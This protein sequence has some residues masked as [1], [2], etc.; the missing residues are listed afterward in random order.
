MIVYDITSQDSFENVKTWLQEIEKF[1]DESVQK[2]LV[3]NKTD[4]EEKREVK[5]ENGQ[6]F[7]FRNNVHFLET[8]AKDGSNVDLCFEKLAMA[9]KDAYP[10]N[11]GKGVK[12]GTRVDI[13]YNKKSKVES[14]CCK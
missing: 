14:G 13:K 4:L 12:N 3:G 1:A 9:I 7:A 11:I 10:D 6:N 5:F 2:I 8:S